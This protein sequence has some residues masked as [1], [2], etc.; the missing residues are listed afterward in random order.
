MLDEA[1]CLNLIRLNY[2]ELV[3][4]Y[5]DLES[6]DEETRNNAGEMVLQTEK[7]SKKLQ[8]IYE[9]LNPDYEE[10]PTYDDYIELLKNS[11]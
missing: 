4:I 8:K 6:D 3:G 1:D 9:D 5:T 7:L 10:Y 11:G 2:Y